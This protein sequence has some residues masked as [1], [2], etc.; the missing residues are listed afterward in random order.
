MAPSWCG[1]APVHDSIGYLT[2]A[3]PSAAFDGWVALA[4]LAAGRS[5]FGQRLLAVSPAHAEQTEV[6]VVSPHMLDPENLRVR[7]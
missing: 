3:T 5:R 4:L 2:S 6:E 7:A 1:L